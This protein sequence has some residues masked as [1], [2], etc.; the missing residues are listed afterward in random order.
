M[1]VLKSEESKAEVCP[2]E[3]VEHEIRKTENNECMSEQEKQEETGSNR[4]SDDVLGNIH[5]A[6][7]SHQDHLLSMKQ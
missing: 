2:V 5:G 6:V 1:I 7:E 4:S 3:L